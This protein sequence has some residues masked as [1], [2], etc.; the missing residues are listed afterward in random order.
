MSSKDR[1]VNKGGIVESNTEPLNISDGNC[2]HATNAKNP[3]NTVEC[4]TEHTLGTDNSEEKS[5]HD[6][7]K[8][9]IGIV[10]RPENQGSLNVE[11]GEEPLTITTLGSGDDYIGKAETLLRSDEF[12]NYDKTQK[13]LFATI[14][15]LKLLM[16]TVRSG[17]FGFQ[18][19][20]ADFNDLITQS[21]WIRKDFDI[22]GLYQNPDESVIAKDWFES[23]IKG[24]ELVDKAAKGE[25]DSDLGRVPPRTF[26]ACL[27]LASRFDPVTTL[28]TLTPMYTLK[29]ELL[30]A[31]LAYAIQRCATGFYNYAKWMLST[32]RKI[33]AELLKTLNLNEE[34]DVLYNSLGSSAKEI[35][36]RIYG[37][38]STSIC[39]IS[40]NDIN[41][42]ETAS[43][44]LIEESGVL[45]D[46]VEQYS[47]TISS[48]KKSFFKAALSDMFK[49]YND[50]SKAIDKFAKETKDIV[51]SE[52][53]E[54]W[55]DL[56]FKMKNRI[57][58][59]LVSLDIYR[60]PEVI[61][62]VTIWDDTMDYVEIIDADE[63]EGHELG[64][65]SQVHSIGFYVAYGE[66]S[67]DYIEKTK[68]TVYRSPQS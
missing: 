65:I 44:H 29:K 63:E 12:C 60:N 68:V 48:L 18:K 40:S 25:V 35:L 39:E 66:G 6:I 47:A 34:I 61:E 56:M 36:S 8:E 62:D 53:K 9:M 4:C 21:G 45:Y 52:D 23:I 32:E 30:D 16:L 50:V 24:V 59:F 58:E 49:M 3:E 26:R 5:Q 37:E 57:E 42:L 46:K 55:K 22:I 14:N 13:R 15:S 17:A 38:L 11:K 31:T 51:A 41:W 28:S 10:E 67:K 7:N 20:S 54:V 19:F 1:N 43:E 27:K 33:T 2:D 64:M